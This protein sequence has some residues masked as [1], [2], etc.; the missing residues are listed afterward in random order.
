MA[1]KNVFYDPQWTDSYHNAG[2][3]ESLKQLAE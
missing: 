1:V 3:W 2:L